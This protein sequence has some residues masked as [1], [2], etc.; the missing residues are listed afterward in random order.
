[1]MLDQPTMR[2][3]CDERRICAFVR[4][5]FKYQPW[6]RIEAELPRFVL[7]EG[8]RW[9]LEILAAMLT[10]RRS[11]K[12]R[13]GNV[14]FLVTGGAGFIGS[15]LVERLV[16][17]GEQVRVLDNFS[18]GNLENLKAVR[19][20]IQ[21]LTGDV[22]DTDAVADAV[23]SVEVVFHQAAVASVPRSIDD[24]QTTVAANITGTLNL[25]VAARDAGC[26]RVVFASSSAVYGDVPK[27]PVTEDM[28]PHPLSP[29]A[30]S[31]L[32]GEQL[33]GVFT[34]LYGLE[35]V[36][37]RYFNVFGPRQDPASAYAAVIPAFLRALHHGEA[38]V[39]YGDGEQSRDF[40]FVDNVVDANLRAAAA[41][42]VAGRVFNVA[43]GRAVSVTALLAEM[44]QLVG[45]EARARYDSARPGDIKHSVA[46]ITAARVGL[47]YEVIVGLDEGLRRTVRANVT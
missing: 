27:I 18:S 9:R 38:P 16:Q 12:N 39:I 13:E 30:I 28:P 37:L 35:T 10:L 8:W 24:P 14:V 22:A 47:G 1:M 19:K 7:L 21:V 5:V 20:N 2:E 23:E 17:R 3:L 11:A 36:A 6:M 33:C 45:N 44:A 43:S 34:R 31:K 26:R 15:H 32:T 29:Y 40:T 41:A 4:S 42:G 25:L 46:D